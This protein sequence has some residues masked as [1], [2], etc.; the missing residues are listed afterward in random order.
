MKNLDDIMAMA[1]N[2]QNE[3]TK[4]QAN[5]DTIEVD[6]QSGGGLVKVR[7]SA[8]GR[9]LGVDIDDSLLQVSEKQM[10]EDLIVAAFNDARAKADAASS[11]EMS[12]LT[13]G[14]PLPPGFKLPF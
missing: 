12:K 9:I 2:V 11:T 6:G 5:L 10:L 1:Q 3:L 4:A 8:K 7:A 14:L 13:S